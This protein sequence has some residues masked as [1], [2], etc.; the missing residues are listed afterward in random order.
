MRSLCYKWSLYM[1]SNDQNT[2]NKCIFITTSQTGG[3][4]YTTAVTKELLSTITFH[5]NEHSTV[6]EV[7]DTKRVWGAELRE[8]GE[9]SPMPC[10][11]MHNLGEIP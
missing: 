6:N 9:V 10:S 2:H 3:K 8:C 1:R 11:S 7:I 5:R 4:T